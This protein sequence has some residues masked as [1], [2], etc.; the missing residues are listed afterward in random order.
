M[1]LCLVESLPCSLCWSWSRW[2]GR[3]I[4]GGARPPASPAGT[5][6]PGWPTPGWPA[7]R[8][9]PSPPTYYTPPTGT[10]F[11][12]ISRHQ[13]ISNIEYQ[14]LGWYLGQ[15]LWWGCGRLRG[16]VRT[17]QWEQHT[18]SSTPESVSATG[19]RLR[20]QDTDNWILQIVQR[21]EVSED[22]PPGAL[23]P[24]KCQTWIILLELQSPYR[25]ETAAAFKMIRKV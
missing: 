3:H 6:S 17:N 9:R 25:A 21:R 19:A 24:T 7:G 2:L 4:P 10:L 18:T 13:P 20:Y 8:H 1:E 15:C 12:H 22:C 16:S 11:S 5:D 14:V 23:N